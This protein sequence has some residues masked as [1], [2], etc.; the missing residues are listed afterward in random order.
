MLVVAVKPAHH[1]LRMTTGAFGHARGAIA[2]G[3]VVKG[4]KPL[5]APG[6]RGIQGL[7]AQVRHRLAPTVMI[8]VQHR[9]EPSLHGKTNI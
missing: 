8:N 7:L 3:D 1:G 9:S 5:A 2:S 6:M 4:E